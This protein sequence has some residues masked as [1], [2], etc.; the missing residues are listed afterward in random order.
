MTRK[1]RNLR[2]R[3]L[4]FT[5]ITMTV[6]DEDDAAASA[7]Q[8][9]LGRDALLALNLQ[10]EENIEY[11]RAAAQQRTVAN[12]A[13]AS[14]MTGTSMDDDSSML[15]GECTTPSLSTREQGFDEF[16]EVSSMS[17]ARAASLSEREEEDEFLLVS[18]ISSAVAVSEEEK[19]SGS[20][21]L[22][23]GEDTSSYDV[24]SSDFS[25]PFTY[26]QKATAALD[27]ADHKVVADGIGMIPSVNHLRPESVASGTASLSEATETVAPRG[28]R[29]AYFY[30]ILHP[31]RGD[32][33]FQALLGQYDD[34][35]PLLLNI[36]SP[37]GKAANV[38]LLP[39]NPTALSLAARNAS[40]VQLDS[41]NDA[42]RKAFE[43][44]LTGKDIS[45]C[46]KKLTISF[47]AAARTLPFCL[48]FQLE[49]AIN[50]DSWLKMKRRPKDCDATEI[51]QRKLDLVFRARKIMIVFLQVGP[52]NVYF[53][54]E[55]YMLTFSLPGCRRLC[56][57]HCWP[58]TGQSN[59][60]V[61]TASRSL[62]SLR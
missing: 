8:K 5:V 14:T 37:N 2:R 30:D 57:H 23:S 43:A 3:F 1:N 7:P 13:A 27:E 51:E 56:Y 28:I 16:E 46:A 4:S 59:V 19:K 49:R 33:V 31:E 42:A 60:E 35:L 15:V 50:C 20:P 21:V 18:D 24:L 55:Y 58:L 10:V 25:S 29:R 22:V 44:L 12:E 53:I 6:S 34:T 48:R 32:P 17:V 45:F 26:A 47:R 40:L 41:E 36:T 9:Q 11:A 61:M 39:T 54:L 62:S 52:R 38:D